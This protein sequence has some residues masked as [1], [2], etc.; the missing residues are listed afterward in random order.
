MYLQETVKNLSV[1]TFQKSKTIERGSKIGYTLKSSRHAPRAVTVSQ[2][3]Y[4]HISGNYG[5]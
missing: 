2:N 1:L 4:E 3:D 5:G